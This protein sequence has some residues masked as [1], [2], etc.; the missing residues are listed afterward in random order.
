MTS[1]LHPFI[2]FPNHSQRTSTSE[3]V[4]QS[5]FVG[6]REAV[7]GRAGQRFVYVGRVESVADWIRVYSHEREIKG[8]LCYSGVSLGS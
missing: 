5:R 2:Q 6:S 7:V 3:N 1:L 8:A 4:C